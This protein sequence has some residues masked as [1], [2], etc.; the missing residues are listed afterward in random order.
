MK[1]TLIACAALA[2]LAS[3][4]QAQN[5]TIYG[6]LDTGVRYIDKARGSV[7]A[8]GF[9]TSGAGDSLT[10]LANGGIL[11][12][13]WG[14]RGSEDLGGGLKAVFNLEGDFDASTG[15]SRG[16]GN[17]SN[18]LFGR[19]SNVGLSAGWGTVLLG[20][21]YSPALLADLGTEPR[22][23]KE[24][25]S[26]L[27]TFAATQNPANNGL[28]GTRN[29]AGIFTS[30][31]ISYS[32]SFGPVN[33]GLG[34]GLGEVAGSSSEGSTI[35][36]G[37]TYTG[38]AAFGAPIIVSGSYQQID[39]IDVGGV[40]S[41]AQTTR[42]SAGVAVPFGAFTGRVYF[43]NATEDGP[44]GNKIADTDNWG[45]GVDWRWNPQNTL[46]AAYYYGDDSNNNDKTKTLVLSNDL[47]LSKR[48]TIYAQ[49]VYVDSSTPDGALAG[50]LGLSRTQ[51]TLDATERNEKASIFNVGIKH[52]F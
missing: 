48:T 51:V 5:V 24:S 15:G 32:N 26:S 50:G 39:G 36:V 40:G 3:A 52:D 35:S 16:L 37:L 33:V 46:T 1:K 20:R 10:D 43:S 47:A 27:A 28:G 19:Q 12:S 21:Q 9:A 38:P 17:I 22:G 14:F 34:Y 4:A 31:L 42:W 8:G 11:P 25:Y 7:D 13:I 44:T 45:F 23:F 18:G 49:Y 41:D 2:T 29:G 30:N 6:R